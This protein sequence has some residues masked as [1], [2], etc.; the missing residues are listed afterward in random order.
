VF[1]C[2]ITKTE[3]QWLRWSEGREGR[4]LFSRLQFPQIYVVGLEVG[5]ET[6]RI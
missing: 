1:T 4:E 2:P 3:I 6:L 5:V